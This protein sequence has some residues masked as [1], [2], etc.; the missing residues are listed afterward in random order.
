MILRLR[1]VGTGAHVCDARQADELLEVLGDE[2]RSVVADD[3]RPF[4]GELV[5]FD[6]DRLG[7]RGGLVSEVLEE[8][9]ERD[10]GLG[11]GAGGV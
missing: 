9:G 4:L 11:R 1:I 2:L 10:C 7:F 6:E 8:V 5:G 3:P